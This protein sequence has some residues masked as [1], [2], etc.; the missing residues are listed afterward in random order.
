MQWTYSLC[1]NV[2]KELAFLAFSSSI[3]H[4]NPKHTSSPLHISQ[5][6]HAFLHT[7]TH[8][9]THKYTHTHKHTNT[10]KSPHT[11]TFKE[12]HTQWA[13]T[14]STQ[15]RD[16]NQRITNHMNLVPHA[17]CASSRPRHRHKHQHTYTHTRIH[18][19]NH[20]QLHTYTQTFTQKREHVSQ[21]QVTNWSP[22]STRA[23]HDRDYSET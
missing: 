19:D 1:L 3:L 4:F 15:N 13:L 9:Q 2:T 18:P 16:W 7:R 23:A 12:K 5:Y 11:H 22:Q 14:R 17:A 20:T 6:M 21:G 10:L 8:T